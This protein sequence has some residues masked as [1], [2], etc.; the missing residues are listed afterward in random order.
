MPIMPNNS[1][2][3]RTMQEIGVAESK[4]GVEVLNL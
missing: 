1:Q 3:M 4:E 2:N